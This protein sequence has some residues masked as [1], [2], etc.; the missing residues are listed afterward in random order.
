MLC[1]KLLFCEDSHTHKHLAGFYFILYGILVRLKK[2]VY[3]W[4]GQIKVSWFLLFMMS[5]FFYTFDVN[6]LI[7]FLGQEEIENTARQCRLIAK[8]FTNAPKLMVRIWG[9]VYPVFCLSA[10]QHPPHPFLIFL[11]IEN[12]GAVL[13]SCFW[14]LI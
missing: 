2:Y 7:S 1:M 3:L 8:E 6:R 13:F 10:T 4:I 11:R 9:G 12:K 5:F 14:C